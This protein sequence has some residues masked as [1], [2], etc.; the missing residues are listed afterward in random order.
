M[1]NIICADV[2]SLV[3]KLIPFHAKNLALTS[4][5]CHQV[6]KESKQ[7]RTGNYILS[8]IQERIINDITL[9]LKLINEPDYN[10]QPLII[11]SNISTGKTAAILAF[12]MKCEGTVVIMVPFVIMS[13]WSMELT[14]MY[15][16]QDKI[17]LLHADYNKK[18]CSKC[19]THGYNPASINKKVII[20]SNMIKVSIK[21]LTKHS[22]VI[23]DEVHKR[24]TRVHDIPKFIGLS[25][26]NTAW[27]HANIKIYEEEETLPALKHYDLILN[28]FVKINQ[29]IKE[30]QKSE[31]GPYLLLC[32]EEYTNELNVIYHEYDKKLNTLVGIKNLKP[33]EMLLFAPG[34]NST[35]INLNNFKCI[36]FVHPC[37]H[38]ADTVVQSIG[39]VTRVTN[40]EKEIPIYNI[41]RKREEIILYHSMVSENE[42]I[43]FCKEHQLKIN[44]SKRYKSFVLNAIEKLLTEF[45]MDQL[46]KVNKLCFAC[47]SRIAVR[48]FHTI[49]E[50]MARDLKVNTNMI[51]AMIS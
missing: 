37:N 21:D 7:I 49:Y 43:K 42:L 47:L 11:Q 23:M 48:D 28:D 30:I 12:S 34:P 13:H 16:E 10:K 46:L 35:G 6:Y 26:S 20:V 33:S 24:G 25:A 40:Y 3:Y 22:V 38:M 44:N 39:R 4:K 51:R 15:G 19:Y 18:L 8:S 45:T 41:H 5:F 27:I 31:A 32:S 9:H 17:I 14:K 29:K 1:E 2:L 50:M 36:I